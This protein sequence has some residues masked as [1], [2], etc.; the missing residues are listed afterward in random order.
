[1]KKLE[2]DISELNQIFVDYHLSKTEEDRNFYSMYA[3][4]YVEDNIQLRNYWER[5]VE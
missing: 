1:M 4:L 5:L 2:K 3:Y